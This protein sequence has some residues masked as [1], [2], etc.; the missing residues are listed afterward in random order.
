MPIVDTSMYRT[1]AD[2]LSEMVAQIL[3]AVPDAY[4]GDDGVISILL[5]IEAGQLENLYLANQLLLE[6]MFV[7]T[8]S[9]QALLRHGDQFGLSPDL[10]AQSVGSL[11]FQGDGGTYIP[12]GS[13]VG[14]DP[15]GGLDVIYFLT[16]TDGT[17]PNPGTPTAPVA[18]VSATAGVL[19]GTYEYAVTFVTASGET[20][21]GPV[22]NPVS[23]SS[24]Q[25]NLTAVPL[26]GTGTTA[27]N[28]Y[29]DKNGAGNWRLIATI[30]DNT[31]TTYADNISDATHDAGA[32]EP[33]VDTA[34]SVIVL[35]Q[36]EDTG[37]DGNVAIGTITELTNAPSDLV[38]V[39]NTTAFT[40][41]TDPEDTEDFRQRLL[42][43]I[44][45]PQTGSVQDMQEWAMEVAGV[46][47]ATAVPNVPSA[48]Q[49]T[50]YISGPG[51][52]VPGS[53]VIAA[54]LAA[55]QSQDLA[56]ITISVTTFTAV[57]TNV[58]VDATTDPA[59][60]LSD[61]SAS[62]VNAIS[63]YIN[64]LE[65]GGTL[66][67]SGIVDAVFGLAGI[68]DVTVTTPTTN[69]TTGATSK[70]TVGTISVT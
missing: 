31:T 19:I 28:I 50:V 65:V 12:I 48:G 62:V 47:Q 67:L 7:Q 59:Y 10:G 24:K 17:I 64:N 54:V 40:G 5:T 32:L 35:G 52:S 66:Y 56:N 38:A 15:G 30:A 9:Y 34:H 39:V 29:R 37:A 22:S 51:G 14:Y 20:L 44:Q 23:P 8:A 27:R 1:Q 13:E 18:A 61:V 57:P 16:T 4:T 36:S 45:N 42:Q 46:D 63:D 11:Q 58:T 69:Q 33:T 21:G 60:A 55:L 53:D 25:V 6:D 3:A 49:V 43:F 41:A 68:I 70:R 26:G 2:I